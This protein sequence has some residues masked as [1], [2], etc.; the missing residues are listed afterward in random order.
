MTTATKLAA[1][2]YTRADGR[3]YRPEYLNADTVRRLIR[4][5]R[6]NRTG[7]E[8]VHVYECADR[9]GTPLHIAY[10]RYALDHWSNVTGVIDVYEI[11]TAALTNL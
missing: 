11:P 5:A 6:T 1:T 9:D 7:V 3:T 4:R 2:L 10:V 8:A